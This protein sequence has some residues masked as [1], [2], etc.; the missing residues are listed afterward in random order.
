MMRTYS[1]FFDLEGLKIERLGFTI[2]ALIGVKYAK[3]V[4]A[5]GGG[6][7]IRP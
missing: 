6:G 5:G 2:K 3:I 4:E 7:M 1:L